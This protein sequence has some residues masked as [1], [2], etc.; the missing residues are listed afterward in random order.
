VGLVS[1]LLDY[2]VVALAVGGA[3]LWLVRRFRASSR[4]DCSS[5]CGTCAEDRAPAELTS[6]A[7]PAGSEA[8]GSLDQLASVRR[9]PAR[10]QRRARSRPLRS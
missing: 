10:L 4:G 3:A 8:P 9:L 6:V 7:P 2:A 1:A 5:G